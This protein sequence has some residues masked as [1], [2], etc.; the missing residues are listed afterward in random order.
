MGGRRL[1]DLSLSMSSRVCLEPRTTGWKNG[2]AVTRDPAVARRGDA[3]YVSP[4]PVKGLPTVDM[5]KQCALDG[6]G[7]GVD[8]TVACDLCRRP[9][10]STTC[11]SVDRRFHSRFC[12][13]NYHEVMEQLLANVQRNK[14]RREKARG[15]RKKQQ[16]LL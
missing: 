8:G 2:L 10:C 3:L 9:Y 7:N 13:K 6:C 15:N 12:G 5:F 11:M 16:L 4:V 1:L 14:K